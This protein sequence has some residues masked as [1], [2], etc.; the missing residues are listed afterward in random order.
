MRGTWDFDSSVLGI[1]S[2]QSVGPYR[3]PGGIGPQR[4]T[5]KT[6]GGS[7]INGHAQSKTGLDSP[8]ILNRRSKR[9]TVES[10]MSVDYG[11]ASGAAGP[12][13]T[14]MSSGYAESK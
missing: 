7:N 12:W 14:L 8:G 3:S 10:A 11:A 13:S 1:Y 2:L 9:S 4:L 6:T 5:S